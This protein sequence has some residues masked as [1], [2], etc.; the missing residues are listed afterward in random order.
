[1][2]TLLIDSHCHLDDP[3]FD[4]DRS[5]VIQQAVEVGVKT[6]VIPAIRAGEF[7][8]IA[9]LA[10][11]NPV[12]R[13]CAGLHPLFIGDHDQSAWDAVCDRAQAG[14]ITAIGECGLDF[15]HRA[16]Q[17]DDQIG[18]FKKHVELAADTDLPLIIHANGAVEAVLQCV[19][20]Y[21]GARGV[22]HSFNGS[23]EQASAFLKL[24]FKLGFG[25]AVTHTRASRL[26]RL[27]AELPLDSILLETD[28][29]YQ[30]G[31]LRGNA[32]NQPAWI[33][34][35]CDTVA[36]LHNKPA[37]IIAKTTTENATT[38]FALE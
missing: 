9:E 23:A 34:D 37:D 31:A 11:G 18:L 5:E 19:R 2:P 22:I 33:A 36:H 26:R 25:G 10:S 28:A 8:R 16:Q 24:G 12:L 21:A 4:T 6:I 15:T 20:Q 38:L 13:A 3:C 29:P 35:V 7:D 1:M 17:K 30:P 14:E 27:V 32:R